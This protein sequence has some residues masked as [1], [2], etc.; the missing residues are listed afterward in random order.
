MA[1]IGK[2]PVGGI[3]QLREKEKEMREGKHGRG[4]Q[5]C[6]EILMA[7]GK[8]YDAERMV[9][10]TSVHIAG[11]YTVMADEGI[12]WLEDLAHDGAKVGVFTTKN[13]EMFDFEDWKELRVPENVSGET[14]KD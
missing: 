8:C 11:N 13:P 2:Q 3:M 6:M 9:P 12:E 14:A 4:H 10:V 5:R 7:V 1:G